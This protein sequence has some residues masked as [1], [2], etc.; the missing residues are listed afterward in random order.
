MNGIE[1]L[2]NFI[3]KNILVS[4]YDIVPCYVIDIYEEEI[5]NSNEESLL[6]EQPIEIV[7]DPIKEDCNSLICSYV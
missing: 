7:I 3:N 1:V 2:I 6:D 5:E 4:S